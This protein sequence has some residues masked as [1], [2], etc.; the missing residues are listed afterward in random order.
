[1]WPWK[2]F[3]ANCGQGS[4]LMRNV[5][6]ICG[7][8]PRIADEAGHVLALDVDGDAGSASKVTMKVGE[9]TK[10]MVANIPGRLADLL[11]I[12][13]YVHCADQFVRRDSPQMPALG[14]DW[15]RTFKFCIAVRDPAFWRQPEICRRLADALG[16]LSGDYYEFEFSK[17]QRISA[18]QDYLDFGGG[19]TAAGFMPEEVILF[20]GGLDSFAG[21]VDTLL[22]RNSPV[23]L[24]S[25]QS[26]SLVTS[27]QAGL[28]REMQ[29]RAGQNHVLHIGVTINK[30]LE[31]A[32]EFTQRARSFLFATLGFVV[33]HM[34]DRQRVTFFEN[35]IVS[36]INQSISIFT[37]RRHIAGMAFG[38]RIGSYPASF[39]G[40]ALRRQPCF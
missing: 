19:E 33:A 28:I 9:L 25:H 27:I 37:F 40:Y 13:C 20:S 8:A 1:M 23:V 3:A 21:A 10:T 18:P 24:V 4:G 2:K 32:A 22:R 34:F 14:R 29:L 11:E 17:T 15:R 38:K 39:V 12:A 26:S 31:E 6:V 16:F 5:I 35:G 36:I 30:G 7:D